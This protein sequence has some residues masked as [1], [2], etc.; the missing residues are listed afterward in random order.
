MS[1]YL[2]SIELAEVIAKEVAMK[3]DSH[4]GSFVAL[5]AVYKS[6]ADMLPS[7]RAF[8]AQSLAE[9]AGQLACEMPANPNQSEL[10]H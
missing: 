3:S 6:L 5:L 4:S 9:A 8:A 10:F 7:H 2:G 1:E